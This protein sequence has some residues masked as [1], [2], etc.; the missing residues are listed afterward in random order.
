[1][2]TAFEIMQGAIDAMKQGAYDYLIKPLDLDRVDEVVEQCFR[3]R[4]AQALARETS[5]DPPGTEE[6]ALLGRDAAMLDVYKMIGTVARTRTAILLR[7]ET[8][9]GKELIARTI[10]NNSP[11]ADEPFVAINCSAVPDTLL[12]SELFGHMR[13]A[14]TGATS[15]RKGRFEAAGSGT[16]FLDEI[17]DTSLSFQAKL[18]RV[19]QERE[20]Y[21]VGSDEPRRT[22][23]RV[24]AATH[25]NMEE[26]LANSQ[27]REDLYFRL[28]VIEI[29]VP[30]LRERRGDIPV[31]CEHIL[32]KVAQEID[33]QVPSVPDDVMAVLLSY[34]WPG[35]VRELEN[36]LTRAVVMAK[37]GALSLEHLA[38]GARSETL[39]REIEA[40]SLEAIERSHVQR[41]LSKAGGNKSRAARILGVSRPRLDRIISRHRLVV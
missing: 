18:L 2:I 6:P 11:N 36:A 21:P 30:P 12:E 41:I 10:H 31:L 32:S 39:E 19:L 40:E 5:E 8:G 4:A 22:N 28:R 35:N 20:F 33:A 7:G 23:A 1:M 15:D 37:G 3:D 25:R 17:G 27:L 38:L 13:G 14:F 26:M 16:I 34:D 29:T 9:T 24:L